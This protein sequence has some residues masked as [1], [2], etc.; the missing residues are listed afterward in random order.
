[1]ILLAYHAFANVVL[2]YRACR[3]RGMEMLA[4]LCEREQQVR[5]VVAQL[6]QPLRQTTALTSLGRA[7]WE[8]LVAQVH[9]HEVRV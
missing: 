5:Q 1:M 7:L 4:N 6:E 9:A 2:Y 8:P 3:S